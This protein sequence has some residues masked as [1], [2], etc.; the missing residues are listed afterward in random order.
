MVVLRR[1]GWGFTISDVGESSHCSALF[2]N[3]FQAFPTQQQLT[4]HFV[5]GSVVHY[6]V[7]ASPGLV[8]EGPCELHSKAAAHT[9]DHSRTRIWHDIHMKL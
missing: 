3:C 6:I 2:G 7:E 5:A 4:A 9:S 8:E 1:I